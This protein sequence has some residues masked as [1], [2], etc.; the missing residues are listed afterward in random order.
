MIRILL[1]K[2]GMAIAILFVV[3]TLSFFLAPSSLGTPHGRS[4]A[5]AQRSSS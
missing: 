3:V 2:V 1:A 5:T 4:S